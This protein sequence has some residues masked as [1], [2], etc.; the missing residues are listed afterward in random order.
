MFIYV[1][2]GI[3]CIAQVANYFPFKF[4]CLPHAIAYQKHLHFRPQKMLHLYILC[5]YNP[6]VARK[7]SISVGLFLF[8]EAPELCRILSQDVL[9][10]LKKLK[11]LNC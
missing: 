4:I 10:E 7:P 11:N 6:Y 1:A 3:H 5:L 8:N 2:Y 9:C